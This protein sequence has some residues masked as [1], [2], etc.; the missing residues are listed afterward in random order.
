MRW[1]IVIER[2]NDGSFCGYVPDLPGIGVGA[3]APEAVKLKLAEAIDFYLEDAP[4]RRAPTTRVDWVDSR[5]RR[6]A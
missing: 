1:A 5:D 2:A 4:A 6:R 3:D